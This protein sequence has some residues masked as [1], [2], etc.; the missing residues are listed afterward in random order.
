MEASRPE[1]ARRLFAPLGPSYERAGAVLSF[2]QDPLWRRFLVSRVPPLSNVLDVAT[3]TGAVAR[4]L[5]ERGCTVTGLDQSPGMLA[6]ARER[7]GARAV[8]LEGRAEELPFEDASFDALTFTYLLRY[9]EEPGAVMR[10]L[11]RVVRPGGTVA[12]LEFFVPRTPWRA[13]WSLYVDRVLPLA[14][15]ALGPEWQEVGHFL[16][17]SIRDF[18]ARL[19]LEGLLELWREAAIA[20]PRHRVL[21]LGG[22]IVVWGQRS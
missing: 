19:P 21:S 15:G 7:L 5:L 6:V 12:M 22:G 17:P 3:G 20:E 13:S 14:G 1:I 4:L 2:G 9:V 11:A 18:W 16:G 8:F 10:E